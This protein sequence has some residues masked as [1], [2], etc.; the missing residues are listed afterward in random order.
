MITQS[1]KCYLGS[2]NYEIN[3]VLDVKDTRDNIIG[4][5]FVSRCKHCG[6]IKAKTVFTTADHYGISKG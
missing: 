2:H 5:V 3:E 6:K 1:L 4:K